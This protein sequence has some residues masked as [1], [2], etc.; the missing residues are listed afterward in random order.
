MRA[1]HNAGPL[2]WNNTLATYASN[3]LDKVA[4]PSQCTFAH[5]QG[6]YGENLA[7]GYSS[8]LVGME[9]WYNEYKKYNFAAGQFSE[10]T[11]HFT[12]MVWKGSTNVG[13]ATV[14]C[15]HPGRDFLVCEYYPRGNYIGQFTENVLQ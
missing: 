14:S 9:A 12:Q 6:P 8:N 5:S 2:V 7:L 13:C 11:G 15:G 4:Q 10:D 1:K 3:Y